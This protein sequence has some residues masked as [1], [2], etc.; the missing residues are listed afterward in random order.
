MWMST[1]LSAVASHLAARRVIL[2]SQSPRRLELLRECG[3][4]FDVVPSTFEENLPKDQFPSPELYVL[5]NA[6]QK[7]HEVMQ[8]AAQPNAPHVVIG[9]DTVVVHGGQ[10][11]EKPRDEDD[12]FQMLSKLSGNAHEVYSGVAIFST[13]LGDKPH[14]FFEK[15]T[16]VFGQLEDQDIKEY[17]KTGEPMDKAGSYGLQGRA[18]VFVSEIHG[19]TNNVIGFPVQRFG[20]E[21]KKLAAEGKL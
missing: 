1:M 14:L 12:A 9:C 7:A 15:T 10:I 3:I 16:V 5:E 2:A 20:T 19:C 21:M 11:L 13:A 18:R 17:I 6:K 4:A 8:R